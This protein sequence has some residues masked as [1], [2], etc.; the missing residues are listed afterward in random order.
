MFRHLLYALT[1]SL[2]ITMT[3]PS[4]ATSALFVTE[5]E[6]AHLSTAVIIGQITHQ[7]GALH[8]QWQRPLTMTTVAVEEVLYGTA[9]REIT[10]E[11]VGGTFGDQIMYIPGDAVLTLGERVVLFVRQIDDNWYLTALQQ[12][13]YHI[14]DSPHG[15]RLVREM[16]NHGLFVRGQANELIPYQAPLIKPILTLRDLRD[17]LKVAGETR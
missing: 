12:S 16:D 10:I 2:V 15:T 5:T 7:R 13:Q 11:Q 8:S 9:P 3:T 1:L 6:Q 4:H 14:E 17:L